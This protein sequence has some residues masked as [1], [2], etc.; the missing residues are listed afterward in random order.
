MYELRIYD[1]EKQIWWGCCGYS[2]P[3]DQ[4]RKKLSPCLSYNPHSKE[5]KIKMM[6]LHIAVPEEEESLHIPVFGYTPR[7]WT[8]AHS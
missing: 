2:T 8:I 6:Y 4:E 3:F 5:L 1:H 7:K